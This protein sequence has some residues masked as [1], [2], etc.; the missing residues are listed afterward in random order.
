MKKNLSK[1]E[2]LYEL[3]VCIRKSGLPKKKQ[4][5]L[6]RA[7][8]VAEEWTWRVVGISRNALREHARNDFKKPKGKIDRHH[9]RQSFVETAKPMLEGKEIMLEDE[10]RN[11]IFDNEEV[12]LVTK[13][14]HHSNNP[15][16]IIDIDFGLG[17]FRNQSVG[18]RY[19]RKE[20]AEYLKELARD[21]SI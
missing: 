20:E 3:Y 9:Y 16:A 10:W 19:R 11:Q 13:E 21:N 17:F 14:E 8:L 5:D 18:Y 1:I 15:S 7:L 12:W 2:H 6:V 4:Y